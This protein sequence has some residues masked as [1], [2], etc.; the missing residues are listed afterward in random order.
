MDH[1]W[2]MEQYVLQI[3]AKIKDSEIFLLISM[4]KKI[5]LLASSF[6]LLAAPLAAF[7]GAVNPATWVN[8]VILRLLTVVIYPLFAGL[9]VIMSI[10]AGIMFLTARGDPGKLKTAQTT[11]IWIVIGITVGL[12]AY[13]IIGLVRNII[14]G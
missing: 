2:E 9:V 7:A 6:A 5:I 3:P 8:D 1:I 14:G 11:F 12:L 13:V 10:Y 4:N